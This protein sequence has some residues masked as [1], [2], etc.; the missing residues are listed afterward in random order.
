[1]PAYTS[2]L[3]TQCPV[4]EPQMN[5]ILGA[6]KGQT[7]AADVLLTQTL[8]RC[9]IQNILLFYYFIIIILLL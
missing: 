4:F 7:I 5:R 2:A 6:P 8:P 3:H 9:D 1:M